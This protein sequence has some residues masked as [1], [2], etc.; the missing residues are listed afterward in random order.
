MY[1]KSILIV[2]AVLVLVAC[3]KREYP[4]DSVNGDEPQIY[5][6]GTID[7]QKLNLSIGQDDYYCFSSYEQRHDSIYVFRGKLA[8]ADCKDCAPS[9]QIELTGNE[10]LPIGASVNTNLAFQAGERTVIFGSELVTKLKIK[11]LSNQA[12]LSSGFKHNDASIGTGSFISISCRQYGFHT[13]DL[14]L[15]TGN[16]CENIIRNTAYVE[17]SGNLLACSFLVDTIDAN[18]CKFKPAVIGGDAGCSYKWDFG[19]GNASTLLAPSHKFEFAGTYPVKFQVIKSDSIIV[20]SNYIVAVGSNNS[21]CSLGMELDIESVSTDLLNTAKVQWKSSD[22]SIYQSDLA[23]PNTSN[24]FEI[25]STVDFDLNEKGEKG[26]L[27]NMKF[28]LVLSNGRRNIT[29]NC[30]RSQIAVGYK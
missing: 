18:T 16:G 22:G 1:T 14:A 2:T 12:I 24:Y 4:A 19:D 10:K 30:N 29:I 9:L 8:P 15:K 17:P 25:I 26:R 20:E 28:N 3:K 7:A 13:F 23:K 21:F 5:F 27:V 11:A 6:E